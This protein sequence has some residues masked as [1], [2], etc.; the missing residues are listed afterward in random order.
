MLNFSP[1]F[2][3]KTWADEYWEN[4]AFEP[5]DDPEYLPGE[6]GRI[7]WTVH[8]VNGTSEKPNKERVM[9]SPSVLI[10]GHYWNIKYYP[11]GNPNEGTEQLSIYLECSN[12]P[13]EIEKNQDSP[14]KDEPRNPNEQHRSRS[15]R[16]SDTGPASSR[17]ELPEVVDSMAVESD[18][19]H[20]PVE[21]GNPIPSP[22]WNLAE[23]NS[24]SAV[25][26]EVA[27][28]I[29]CVIYNPE[30]PRVNVSQKSSHRY[31]SENP[32][33]GWTRF[34][35]PWDEIH[36]RQRFKRQALLRNDTLSFTAYIR[37]VHDDTG[38]LWWHPPKDK[39]EWNSMARIGLK[40]LVHEKF[41]SSALIA[42]LSSWLYF[43]PIRNLI[44]NTQIPDLFTQLGS[45]PKPMIEA[46]QCLVYEAFDPSQAASSF[47]ASL[48]E[49]ANIISWYGE[50]SGASK[51]DVIATWETLRR[52]LNCEAS[53]VKKVAEAKDLFRDI[54][55]LK[56][57]GTKL[58]NH[59]RSDGAGTQ[60][61]TTN[62]PVSTQEA[63]ASAFQTKPNGIRH[64]LYEDPQLNE[65]YPS[66]LQVELHRQMYCV[67][68]RRWKK[69]T[70]HIKIDETVTIHPCQ[71][72][73]PMH[74]T[75]YGMIIHSGALEA[76]DYYSVIRPAGPGTRWIKYAGGK[77][78]KGVTRLTT[79]QACEAHEGRGQGTEGTAAVAYIVLYVRTD[80]LSTVLNMSLQSR[81][82]PTSGPLDMSSSAVTMAVDHSEKERR[83]SCLVYSSD[84]FKGYA[85]RGIL[86]PWDPPASSHPG[87][88][89]II[90]H[91]FEVST[92]LADVERYL[93]ETRREAGENT[94]FRIWLLDTK[95]RSSVRGSPPFVLALGGGKRLDELVADYGGCRFWLQ[96]ISA[97]EAKDMLQPENSTAGPSSNAFSESMEVLE[98]PTTA[99]NANHLDVSLRGQAP[100][101]S[102]GESQHVLSG[103][104]TQMTSMGGSQTAASSS[105]PENPMSR[106]VSSAGQAHESSISEDVSMDESRDGELRGPA[107]P[108]SHEVPSLSWVS[109]T[110]QPPRAHLERVYILIKVFD[111]NS[112]TLCG[113]GG[114][115][116]KREE[117]IGEV[118]R[119]FLSLDAKDKFDVYNEK[120]LLL[121]EKDQVNLNGSFEEIDNSLFLDGSVF[122][123]QHRSQ[124]A[125]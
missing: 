17:D 62:E 19:T 14:T 102:N 57:S 20:V 82:S 12:Q 106:D 122:I 70:H 119:R 99:S 27:A 53:G 40:R 8:G 66:I 21:S 56:I 61:P 83:V 111:S 3:T 34:H 75:L 78:P 86:D 101:N 88:R 94:R 59:L 11:R 23:P 54:C 9:R 64:T 37:I 31:C 63:T 28:Q 81:E 89:P 39:T 79:K 72:R 16:N 98:G 108:V 51:I 33:W 26:W 76:N 24:D 65:Q 104:A 42:A 45:R 97:D 4:H 71:F 117:K 50:D 116:A 93:V 115:F 49:V 13:Y 109:S 52:I 46:L 120:S 18:E 38:A 114:L 95:P 5:L 74:Y 2:D 35:G 103:R 124:A 55:T 22:L 41:Y 1:G 77:D 84:I 10:G 32:D 15:N 125:E 7:N 60:E 90:E 25:P 105:T 87:L 92:T 91:E 121:H 48:D 68:T 36:K 73:D 107:A 123:V 96:A 100:P 85:G 110:D 44:S 29:S 67:K 6:T 43:T 118:I 113:I 69:L 112:Q 30:E 47:K 80:S 58:E